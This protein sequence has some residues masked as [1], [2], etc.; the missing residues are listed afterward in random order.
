MDEIPEWEGLGISPAAFRRINRT[1][2]TAMP[3]PARCKEWI[4]AGIP[5]EHIRVYEYAQASPAAIAPHGSQ[6]AD[7]NPWEIVRAL[8]LLADSEAQVPIEI[9]ARY[10]EDGYP[11]CSPVYLEGDRY[12]MTELALRRA[13]DS[14]HARF[15]KVTAPPISWPVAAAVIRSGRSTDSLFTLPSLLAAPNAPVMGACH[16]RQ[17]INR[18]LAKTPPGHDEAGIPWH[19]GALYPAPYDP[20]YDYDELIGIVT[21]EGHVACL[22]P[23]YFYLRSLIEAL[24]DNGIYF[25]VPIVGESDLRSDLDSEPDLGVRFHRYRELKPLLENSTPPGINWRWPAWRGRR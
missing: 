22:M 20:V 23:G 12:P 2:G 16:N 10:V 6:L 3:T 21:Q 19:V 15:E 11:P 24:T 9:I 8:G 4:E 17:R 5:A 7:H 13:V 18:L 25:V 14:P 1:V